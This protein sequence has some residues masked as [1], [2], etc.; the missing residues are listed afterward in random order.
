MCIEQIEGFATIETLVL[1]SEIEGEVERSFA[2]SGHHAEGRHPAEMD[3][4]PWISLS[5]HKKIGGDIDVRI[6]EIG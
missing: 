4:D 6:V 1:V 5:V 3:P 2:P